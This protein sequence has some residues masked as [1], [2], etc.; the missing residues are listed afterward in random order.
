MTAAHAP[1]PARLAG[2]PVT[3]MKTGETLIAARDHVRQG[4]I[5]KHAISS[6][7]VCIVGAV[8][9]AAHHHDQKFPALYILQHKMHEMWPE[10]QSIVKFNDHPG[11][12]KQEV[13]DVF[14][15]AILTLQE[16]GE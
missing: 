9:R 10:F 14:D 12:T 4:W 15:K 6:E 7:G 13:L 2:Q 3:G 8:H 5:Q 11:R 16:R 1:I